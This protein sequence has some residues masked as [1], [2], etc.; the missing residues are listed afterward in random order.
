M[1]WHQKLGRCVDPWLLHSKSL[2]ALLYCVRAS[3]FNRL[4]VIQSKP[5]FVNL[6]QTLVTSGIA[7]C[8]QIIALLKYCA[9]DSITKSYD[10]W[11]LAIS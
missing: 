9:L 10:H 4:I 1:I 5:H 6:S 8:D 2:A 3:S 7:G 11:L